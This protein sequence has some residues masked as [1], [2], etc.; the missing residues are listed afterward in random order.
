MDTNLPTDVL[1][2]FVAIADTG[3]FTKAAER[4]FRTQSAVSQQVQRLEQ[5]LGKPLF[6]REGRMAR[7]T[8]EGESLLGYARRILKLQDEAVSAFSQP[9]IEGTVSFGLADDYV[10]SFLPPILSKFAASHPRVQMEI[11]CEPSK[12]LVTLVEKGKLDVALISWMPGM[13][14]GP[15]VRQEQG[16]WAASEAYVIPEDEP[17]PIAL[18]EDG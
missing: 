7:L 17:I 3:S 4:V 10:T 15:V 2:T 14:R 18:F 5:L 9:D 8:N 6:V 13:P 16:V 1:R 11:R 12:Q